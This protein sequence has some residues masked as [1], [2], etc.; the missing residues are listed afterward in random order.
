MG[1]FQDRGI[2]AAGFYVIKNTAMPAVLAELGFISNPNEERSLNTPQTQQQLA[3][4]VVQ[5]LDD[6]FAQSAR[7]GGGF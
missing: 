5:G 7:K 4:G 6:F 2:T 1:G 3:Q